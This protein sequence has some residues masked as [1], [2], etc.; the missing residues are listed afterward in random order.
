MCRFHKIEI[1]E[2]LFYIHF[3]ETKIFRLLPDGKL[4]KLFFRLKLHPPN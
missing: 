3:W 2:L 4:L 1:L